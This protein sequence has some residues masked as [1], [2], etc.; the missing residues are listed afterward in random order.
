MLLEISIF[1]ITIVLVLLAMPVSNSYTRLKETFSFIIL[2]ILMRLVPLNSS[3]FS[4]T[5]LVATRSIILWITSILKRFVPYNYSHA[6]YVPTR[7]PYPLIPVLY[8]L[9]LVSDLVRPIALTVR[10]VV[11]LSLRHLFIHRSARAAIR[12]FIPIILVFELAVAFIQRFIYSSL[13][14]LW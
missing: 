11:N 1:P 2:F 12:L 7:V 14:S 8:F 5:P 10:I 13:P 9:E 3:V 4:L 6:Y